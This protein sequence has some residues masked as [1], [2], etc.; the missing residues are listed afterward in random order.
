M[1]LDAI[2]S[3]RNSLAEIEST[4]QDENYSQLELILNQSRA[5]YSYKLLTDN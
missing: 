1:M 2:Q 4:L 3:F 5:S